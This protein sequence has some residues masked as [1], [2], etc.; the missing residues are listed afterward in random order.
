MTQPAPPVA[1]E[2]NFRLSLLRLLTEPHTPPTSSAAES[3]Q[4][5]ELATRLP[6]RATQ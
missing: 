6:S 3:R 1:E 5:E 4:L 2:L